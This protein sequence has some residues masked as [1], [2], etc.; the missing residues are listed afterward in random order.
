LQGSSIDL[1]WRFG[2]QEKT[3]LCL[4]NSGR[5]VTLMT[6]DL[7]SR[8]DIPNIRYI[9]H[10]HF[11]HTEIYFFTTSNGSTRMDATSTNYLIL[12]EEEKLPSCTLW[13]VGRVGGRLA[14]K[15][16]ALFIAAGKR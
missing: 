10:Y 14:I 2:Q 3:T 16:S 12:S 13:G 11:T 6:T 5:V 1:S 15:W 9:I 4:V 7:A 8:L